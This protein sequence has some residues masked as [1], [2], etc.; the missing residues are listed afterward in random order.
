MRNTEIY[1]DNF[2]ALK[3]LP[4]V[5]FL[6]K[7]N[8]KLKRE[9]EDLKDTV[10]KLC[11]VKLCNQ[12]F[13]KE[14]NVEED[15][16]EFIDAPIKIKQEV[17]DLVENITYDVSELEEEDDDEN[18]VDE[19]AVDEE[20]NAV[21]EDAAN[22]VDAA[23]AVDENAIEAAIEDENAVEEEED[24]DAANAVDEAAIEQEEEEQEE[25]EEEQEEEEQ[26]E[27]QEEDEEVYEITI[28]SKIYYVMN[29]VD[30]IIYEAD[31]N[32]DISVEAGKYKNGKPVFNKR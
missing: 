20:E 17:I 31:S 23:N 1:K 27:E 8:R 9:N 7:E 10:L 18:A 15:D 3:K 22:V 14:E 2:E 5:K 19:N 6:L 21:E 28:K 16:V 11:K 32:G 30:S 13:I 26:E 24:E 25:E 29:E 4:F 12:V